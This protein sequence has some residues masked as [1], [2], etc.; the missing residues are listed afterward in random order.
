MFSETKRKKTSTID[1]ANFNQYILW[2]F[3][4]RYSVEKFFIVF[5]LPT[6]F[7]YTAV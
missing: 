3:G 1:V 5:L 2:L 4:G 6:L 7:A